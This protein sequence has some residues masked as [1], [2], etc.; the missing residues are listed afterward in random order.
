MLETII[1]IY[2]IVN[3][4]ALSLLLYVG[5]DLGEWWV[6]SWALDVMGDYRINLTGRIVMCII[7]TILFLP[8]MLVWFIAVL[9]GYIIWGILKVFCK[10][11][12]EK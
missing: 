3:V 7:L 12:R 2:M 5:I 8:A 9:I 4:V 1:D 11:F 6:Y 10:I